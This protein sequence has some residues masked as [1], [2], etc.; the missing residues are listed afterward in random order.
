V[1][2]TDANGCTATLTVNIT[3]PSALT[4]SITAQTNVLCFGN[5]TGNATV[6]AAGGT[7]GYTYLWSV[8]GQTTATATGLAAGVHTVTVTDSKSCKS[9]STATITQPT[10]L[11]V[12]TISSTD[13]LC[14]GALLRL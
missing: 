2:A 12:L 4:S 5:T 7:T 14:T 11:V 10:Q 13:P 6:T 1:T 3:Q 8:G 9:V